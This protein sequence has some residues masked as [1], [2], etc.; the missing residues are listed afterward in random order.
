MPPP[1]DDD[2]AGELSDISTK[3][4]AMYGSC[5]HCYEDGLCLDLEAFENIIDS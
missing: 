4:E 3:L 1:F 2:L 5:K